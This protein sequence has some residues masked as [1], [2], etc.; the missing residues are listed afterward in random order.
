MSHG[1]GNVGFIP[2]PVKPADG[3][4]SL[5]VNGAW[6]AVSSVAVSGTIGAKT[7]GIAGI[8]L[9]GN[10]ATGDFPLSLS[11]A[12]LTA[13][14][15][16]SFPD[17]S[18]TVAGL[19]A[20]TFAGIQTLADTT[21]ATNTTTAALVVSGGIACAKNIIAGGTSLTLGQ[22]AGAVDVRVNGGNSGTNGGGR[23]AVWNN[24]A[25]ILQFGNKSAILGGAYDSTP[26]LYA[27]ANLHFSSVL[28]ADDTTDATN[29][30]TAALVCSGGIAAAKKI[31]VG[32]AAVSTTATSGALIVNGGAGIGGPSTF[33]A[34]SATFAGNIIAGAQTGVAAVAGQVGEE[35]KS[36]VTGIAAGATATAANTTSI[37]LTAG[38]WLL[39]G[40]VVISGGATG[41]TSG[42]SAKVSIVSVPA[43]NGTS[44]DTMAQESVLALLANGLFTMAIP[45]K[46]ISIAATT[47]HYLTTEISYVAG[48]P[49]V[50][51]TLTAT[52]VR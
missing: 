27:S 33:G 44:G 6:T 52:R 46:R 24:G 31:I 43:T 7:A 17:R 49:T 47:T 32:S 34:I 19:G 5:F 48:S 35:I 11:P 40:Y 42:T 28:T 26:Y 25:S 18:D 36:T 45:A 1:F 39:S 2:M 22:N 50:A 4:L 3:S 38:D 23:V 37:S 9:D 20:Q 30:T 41:L 14:R 21:D 10:G 12:N 8:I 29:T 15:R 51:G 16:W 13:A